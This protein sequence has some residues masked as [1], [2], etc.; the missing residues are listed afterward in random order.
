MT[1]LLPFIGLYVVVRGMD[2]IITGKNH[3]DRRISVKLL[4]A[5]LI[6][7]LVYGALRNIPVFP[8]ELLAPGGMEKYF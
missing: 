7:I 8:F 3:V 5:V 4:A 6:L 2:W 1:L